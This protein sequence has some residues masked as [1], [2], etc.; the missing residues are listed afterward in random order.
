MMRQNFPYRIKFYLQLRLAYF[1]HYIKESTALSLRIQSKCG[2]M[3]EKWDQNNSKYGHFLRSEK[4]P[5]GFSC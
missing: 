4:K 5:R 3:S 1:R 2:D